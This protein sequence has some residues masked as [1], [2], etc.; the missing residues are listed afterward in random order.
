[1]KTIEIQAETRKALGKNKVKKLRNAK[2]IPVIIYGDGSL[3][4]T[5]NYSDAL[6]VYNL[7]HDTFLIKLSI[8]GNKNKNAL[9]K[10]I[11]M[12]PVKNK[13]NHL[14]FMELIEGKMVSVRIPLE[15][16]GIPEGVKMGGIIEHFLWEINIECLPN[17][18]PENIK[19]DITNLNIGDSIHI[20]D[21]PVA[22]GVRILDKEDQVIL[23][24]GLPTGM[25]EEKE[26]EEI[27]EEEL[28]EGAE[29]AEGEEGAEKAEGEEGEATEGKGEKKEAAEGEKGKKMTPEELQAAMKAKR[30]EDF[31][32][33]KK[34]KK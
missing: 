33:D 15:L 21:L 16:S 28:E 13:V 2:K 10:N 4:L 3:P 9:L 23:T 27:P 5:I 18:I 8:D 20:S 22:E 31:K 6:K 11:Q 14:D 26:E 12:D 25:V 32:S 19:L 29:K 24:I 17:N 1:M 34:K 30:K 7:R